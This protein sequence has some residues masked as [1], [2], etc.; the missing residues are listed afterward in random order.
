MI[1]EL[2]ELKSE[3][4]VEDVK[5]IKECCSNNQ[6]DSGESRVREFFGMKAANYVLQQE[7]PHHRIVCQLKSRGMSNVEISQTLAGL[8]IRDIDKRTVGYIVKQPWAV[9]MIAHEIEKMGKDPVMEK[10]KGALSQAAQV[11]IDTIEAETDGT[12]VKTTDKL[13]AADA[14]FNRLL[15]T[16]KQSIEISDKDEREMSDAELMKIAGNK[17][18]N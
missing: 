7:Q 13:R 6:Q 3:L 4:G 8:G 16:P 15:G 2:N 9:E 1:G 17:K 12:L 18:F 10:L 14:I 11:F 5:E